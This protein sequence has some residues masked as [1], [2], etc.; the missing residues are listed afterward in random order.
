MSSKT[1][2]TNIKSYYELY[3]DSTCSVCKINKNQM[4]SYGFT[5]FSHPFCMDDT[6]FNTHGTALLGQE[7]PKVKLTRT[8]SINDGSAHWVNV[9]VNSS[10][11]QILTRL[12]HHRSCWYRSKSSIDAMRE[13]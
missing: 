1:W 7:S 12:K 4:H 2:C 11:S 10:F 9:K 8:T 6:M 13:V 5:Y 3:T